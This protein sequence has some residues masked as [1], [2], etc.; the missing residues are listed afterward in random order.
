M[1]T[2]SADD[3]FVNLSKLRT[4]EYIVL[5]AGPG[6]FI[7]MFLPWFST[8]GLGRIAGHAGDANVWSALSRPP[9]AYL[10]WCSWGSLILPWLIARG[11]KLSW[12]PG[13]MT[14]VFALTG[15]IL[16][17]FVGVIN[18]PGSPSGSIHLAWGYAISLLATGA[19]VAAGVLRIRETP[20]RRPPPGVIVA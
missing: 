9:I 13:E 5:I 14:V 18:R 1:T 15:V 17:L 20:K 16:I 8:S 10:T 12:T 2:T 7:S 19:L 6:L 11:H 3:R 4:P